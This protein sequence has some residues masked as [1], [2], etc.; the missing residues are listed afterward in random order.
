MNLAAPLRLWPLLVSLWPFLSSCLQRRLDGRVVRSFH[1]LVLR[2]EQNLAHRRPNRHKRDS[3]MCF[4]DCE[5]HRGRQAVTRLTP[6]EHGDEFAPNQ[7]RS[8]DSL[9]VPFPPLSS[10]KQGRPESPRPVDRNA[11][12]ERREREYGLPH[13]YY[14]R[15]PLNP[16]THLQPHSHLSRCQPWGQS[17]SSRASYLSLRMKDEVRPREQRER[18][19]R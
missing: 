15:K 13:D 8:D 5:I 14:G 2:I 12:I 1:S 19:D 3:G 16:W 18:T 11:G 7:R 9:G 4:S 10:S 17:Q 6:K